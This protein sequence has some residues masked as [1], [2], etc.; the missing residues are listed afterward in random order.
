MNTQHSTPTP[1]TRRELRDKINARSERK[2]GDGRALYILRRSLRSLE[3]FCTPDTIGGD[4][5]LDICHAI[6][7][8]E[9]Q[10]SPIEVANVL[11]E[12][13]MTP[14][15]LVDKLH[16]YREL[17]AAARVT[18]YS[19]MDQCSGNVQ[20]FYINNLKGREDLLRDAETGK[21]FPLSKYQPVTPA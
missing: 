21:F 1:I 13:G 3:L 12:T 20:H 11:Y 8:L 9:E 18:I 14:R 16:E 15:E 19:S 2:E 6:D 17:L 5:A 7:E 10:P 4:L